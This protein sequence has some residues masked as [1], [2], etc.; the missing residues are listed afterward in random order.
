MRLIRQVFI[1]FLLIFSLFMGEVLSG[2]RQNV[3]FHKLKL[4]DCLLPEDHPLQ[5]QLKNLFEN[6]D[7][8]KSPQQ[9][10]REGFDI[11]EAGRSGLM[12]ASHP[13]INYLI[14]KFQDKIAQKHQVNNYL[15]RVTGARALR[16]FIKLNN[17]QHIVVP[18]KW[19]YR[20]PNSFSDPKTGEMTY[21][22]IV[23]K[24]DICSGGKDPTGE[25]A[26]RYYT[27]DFDI[28]KEL[29]IVAYHFNGLDSRLDN[30]PFTYENKIAFIDTEHW[31][32]TGKEFLRHAMH[33]LSQDRQE[34]ALA[35]LEALRAQDQGP[36]PQQ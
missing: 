13:A 28:L 1:S 16:E 12:V 22:M 8:F 11:L 20:L 15:K 24:I 18:Q 2:D 35:V 25:V 14:K 27:M 36:N 6:S 19:L 3:N 23:E 21:V 30:M 31:K 7:M 4:N 33:Y 29:C 17:L 10:R 34:Y 5:S 26:R 32:H 9:L